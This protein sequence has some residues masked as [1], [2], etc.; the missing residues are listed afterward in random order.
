MR[1]RS[2]LRLFTLA[3]LF[4]LPFLQSGT[5]HAFIQIVIEKGAA[6]AT[7]SGGDGGPGVAAEG[8]GVNYCWSLP[9]ANLV[10]TS[11]SNAEITAALG[12]ALN[13][14]GGVSMTTSQ[15]VPLDASGD[16]TDP[17]LCFGG[18][19][20]GTGASGGQLQILGQSIDL[21]G[22]ENLSYL[23]TGS[24]GAKPVSGQTTGHV[25]VVIKD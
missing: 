4:T 24:Y 22:S 8:G 16:Y 14:I 1:T 13:I 2:T 7:V 20:L 9:V 17:Q 25:T 15:S 21:S 12:D 6:V 11:H 19:G 18:T 10:P 5:A 23:P 3:S